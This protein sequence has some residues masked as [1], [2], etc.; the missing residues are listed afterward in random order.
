M[1][2]ALKE[3]RI[4]T[5]HEL[6]E[7]FKNLPKQ[8]GYSSGFKSLDRY[9]SEFREG[10]LT[11]IT[12][13]TGEG[14]TQFAVSLTKKLLTAGITPLWFS[15]EISSQELFERFGSELPLFYLPRL[16]TSKAGDW[17]EK[18]IEEAKA[19]EPGLKAIFID[20]LHYLTDDTSVRNRQLP[21]ILGNLCRQ[22]KMLAR[23]HR[24]LIFLLA[25]TR[26]VRGNNTRPTIDDL[27]DSSGIAQEADTVLIIQRVG[28]RRSKKAD[29]DEIPELSSNMKIWIDK[30]RRTGKLGVVEMYFDS[31]DMMHKE[32]FDDDIEAVKPSL[33]AKAP[34]T[35]VTK[36]DRKAAIEK[37]KKERKGSLL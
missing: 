35:P 18:K 30:N 6:Q 9:L 5:S 24:L 28:K 14:K 32:F 10:D 15:F 3:D 27:K 19:K 26:K 21:E 31:T 8:K 34:E 29:D 7:E 1:P 25:H 13:L 2:E 4:V 12:G 16:L 17:I 20:H 37:I 22:F 33:D 36:T 11:I 23:K